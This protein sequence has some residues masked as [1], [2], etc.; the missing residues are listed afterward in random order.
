MW[1]NTV[2]RRLSP[3]WAN[4]EARVQARTAMLVAIVRPSAGAA[5]W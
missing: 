4:A 3:R 5:Y 2:G 1:V